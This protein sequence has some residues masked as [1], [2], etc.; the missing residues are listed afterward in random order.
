MLMRIPFLDLKRQYREIGSEVSRAVAGVLDG[1]SYILGAEVNSFEAEWANF[2][3]VRA[4]ATLNS[5]TDAL[6][7]ALIATGATREGA[8]D[9]V[10]LPALSSGYTALAVINAGG[11]PLFVDIDPRRYTIA[12]AAIEKAITSRTRAIVAVHLYGQMADMNAITEIASRHGLIVIEDAAQAHGASLNGKRA[13]AHGHAAAF[14]FYPTKNLGAYGDGGAVTSDDVELIE[15]IKI[16][17]QGGHVAAMQ[18]STAGRNSRMDE[19]Q[20][21]VLRVKLKHLMDWNR[22]RIELAQIYDDA[23]RGSRIETPFPVGGE[24]HNFHLYVVQHPERERLR[25]YL[26]DREIE[27]MIHYPFLLHQQP[28]FR[29]TGQQAAIPIAE[30]VARRIVSLPLYPQLSRNEV[31]E[32]AAE[33]MAFEN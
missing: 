28:L 2:C 30:H 18:M 7:L 32:V 24:S 8:A 16:L 13:G 14:S 20:A 9:E 23:F 1:G 29:K 17:R 12:P 33:I 3:G 31:E 10:I 27:T 26:F 6:I 11:V 25:R 22:K 15:Q 21:A 19:V 5:G 4:A